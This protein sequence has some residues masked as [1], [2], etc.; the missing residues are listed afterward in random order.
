MEQVSND[1]WLEYMRK[2]GFPENK[3]QQMYTSTASVTKHDMLVAWHNMAGKVQ[4]A[5]PFLWQ[6]CNGVRHSFAGKVLV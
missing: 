4:A 1:D 3:L 6:T 2:L 5:D